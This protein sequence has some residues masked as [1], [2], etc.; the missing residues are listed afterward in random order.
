MKQKDFDRLVE[1]LKTQDNRC[2][3]YPVFLVQERRIV[4]NND[5]VA[6]SYFWDTINVHLTD[7]QADSWIADNRHRHQELRNYA[8]SQ[9]RCHEINDLVRAV[10]DGKVILAD[11]MLKI[12]EQKL[13]ECINAACACGGGGP[14]DCCSACMAWHYWRGNVEAAK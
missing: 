4:Y 5:G 9:Y 8:I 14:D 6:I 11:R 10:R 13:G 3:K 12:W 1:R 2:E 7:E